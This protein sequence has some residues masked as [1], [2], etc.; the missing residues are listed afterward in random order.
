MR[1]IIYCRVSTKEQTLNLSLP[2][3]KKACLNTAIE[4]VLS[5]MKSS[6]MKANPQ[7]LLRDQNFKKCCAIAE[8]T[9]AKFIISLFTH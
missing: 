1:A 6:L 4:T 9:K 5:L 3:Q 8:K 2:T 7:K